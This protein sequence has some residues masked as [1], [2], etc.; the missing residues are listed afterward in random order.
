MKKK[1]SYNFGAFHGVSYDWKNDNPSDS[2]VE[3]VIF[4]LKMTSAYS[5]IVCGLTTQPVVSPIPIL[6]LLDGAKYPIQS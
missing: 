1:I 2:K 3:I 5:S 6:V 4:N